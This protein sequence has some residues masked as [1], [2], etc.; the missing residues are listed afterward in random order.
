MQVLIDSWAWLDKNEVEPVRIAALKKKLII[1]PRKVGDHP[2][3]AP[4]PLHLYDDRDD[5]LGVP[6]QFFLEQNQNRY[7]VEYRT[8]GGVVLPS[9]IKFNPEKVLRAE[10]ARAV[11]EI[12]AILLGGGLGGILQ[13]K[14]G[15][16]K[17]VAACALIAELQAPTL[18]VVHK[19]FLVRQWRERMEEFLP[20]VKIGHVQQDKCDIEGKHVVIAMVGSLTCREY[21]ELYE[22]PRLLMID[23]V[24]RMGAQK[25]SQV[26]PKFPSRW[27][28]GLSAT[29]KRKDRADK[30]FFWHIGKVLFVS[31]EKRL[32]FKVKRI[33]SKFKVMRTPNL[34][35]D[36]ISKELMIRFM[37][38]NKPRNARII[39]VLVE[40]VR[41]GRKILLLST[42]L[43]HLKLLHEALQKQWPED[44]G[45]APT[46]G[47]YIGGMKEKDQ[48][49]SE[50]CKVIFATAQMCTEALDIPPL[51]T[52]FLVTPLGDIEQAAGRILRPFDGKKDPI[53]VDFRDDFVPKCKKMGG[54]RDKQY[55]RIA[56]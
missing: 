54:Y 11:Q 24:H 3:P 34:N 8:S 46:T 1:R 56:A 53:I 30:A 35:P 50:K 14:P 7:P 47:F 5:V 27:R 38:A 37:C 2:G 6:R 55:A 41:A 52:L 51:D 43:K 31:S 49:E 39:E 20:G 22:W 25:W 10:Q 15:W 32:D 44:A 42:R 36:L 9:Q 4:E 45:E 16:G 17:T 28:V 21:P 48:K 33:H 18:V 23:E 29:P 12:S 13:A 26:P 40:A 19:D